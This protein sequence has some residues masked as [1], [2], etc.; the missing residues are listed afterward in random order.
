[1]H[2]TPRESYSGR[3]QDELS[4]GCRAFSRNGESKT[5]NLTLAGWIA[6]AAILA[7]FAVGG[8]R[9]EAALTFLHTQ[10]QDI[11]NEAGEK[12]MLRGVGLGNWMLPEGYMWKF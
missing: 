6:S 5:R 1:M 2:D 4:A 3:M 12:I 9:A 11:V 8:L 10:G 7:G